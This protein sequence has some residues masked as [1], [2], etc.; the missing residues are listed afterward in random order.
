MMQFIATNSNVFSVD[1]FGNHL[2]YC[3]IF[4]AFILIIPVI[5]V[6]SLHWTVVYA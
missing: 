1:S 5:V 4:Y 2:N 3:L 6:Y